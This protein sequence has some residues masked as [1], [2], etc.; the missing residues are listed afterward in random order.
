MY[1]KKLEE[2]SQERDGLHKTSISAK[3]ERLY[4]RILDIIFIYIMPHL[5]YLHNCE[6]NSW[7]DGN[8][9]NLQQTHKFGWKRGHY[10]WVAVGYICHKSDKRAEVDILVT[11]L[12][13]KQ[14][15][16]RLESTE[17]MST[18]S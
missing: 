6:P 7:G 18:L 15:I 17:L 12:Q 14:I 10:I 4:K 3:D 16:L 11:R 5:S 9:M 8:V 2:E 1:T 13:E